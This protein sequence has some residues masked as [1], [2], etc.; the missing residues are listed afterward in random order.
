MSQI[1][2]ADVLVRSLGIDARVEDM[3][4]DE[5][6][7]I[8]RKNVQ[9]FYKDIDDDF[10][11]AHITFMELDDNNQAV[12][13][14][15]TDIPTGVV[16]NGISS[17]IPSEMLGDS[18]RTGFGIKFLDTSTLLIRVAMKLN[19]VN[20][21]MNGEAYRADSCYA[22]KMSAGKQAIL[23]RIYDV[24]NWVTFINPKV[25]LSY[26][27][28]DVNAK[29]LLIIHYSDQ[30]NMTSSGYDA[31][32][33]TRKSKQYQNAISRYLTANGVE[34]VETHAK[35]VINMFNALNGDWL[36]R[37]LS[38]KSHFP[39]EKLS[40]LSAMKIAVKRYAV[41]GVIWVPV[42]LEEILRVSGSVGL[43]Q[44]GS[45][46]SAKNLGFE[47]VT[48]DDLLLIGICPGEKV[49][50][51]FYPIEV[52]IGKVETDYLQKGIKQALKTRTIFDEILGSGTCKD[53]CIDEACCLQR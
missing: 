47:G 16:M 15:M 52:K 41:P 11:Y 53:R 30:Y 3:D 31:I 36:L 50:V 7:D 23:D 10:E 33:V 44:S 32:T 2:D 29:D 17:G 20:A 19:A 14:L 22:L 1:D 8:Y 38:Y 46:F 48:S 28:S 4:I 6:I 27:K 34:D 40:I 49:Q 5:I 37:M 21:A 43:S 51:A 18:Y 26:F 9:F 12:N 39:V 45:M 35:R 24:S 42:S 13:T 25:D